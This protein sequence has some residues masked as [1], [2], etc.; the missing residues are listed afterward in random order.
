MSEYPDIVPI[1][2][3]DPFFGFW[4]WAKGPMWRLDGAYGFTV[5][6]GGFCHQ[7]VIP[8]GYEFDGQ[9]VPGVFHGFP[10]YY[11]PAGVGMRAGLIHDFL[12]DL[13]AGGSPWLRKALGGQL[14]PAPPPEIIHAVYR[15]I[16]LADNQRPSKAK[17]TWL[18]VAAFGPG[19]KLRPKF[20]NPKHPA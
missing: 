5:N 3:A 13:Y 10:F 16:Q 15:D 14:P 1:R 11:G 20:L 7:Y 12:C 19:G 4:P 17:A 9:S 2:D 6:K 8:D 18:A